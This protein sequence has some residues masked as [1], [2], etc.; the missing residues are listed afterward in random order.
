MKWLK[1]ADL[2]DSDNSDPKNDTS[3]LHVFAKK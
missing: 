3:K 1:W 2:N